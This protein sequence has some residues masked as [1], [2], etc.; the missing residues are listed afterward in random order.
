MCKYNTIV[1]DLDGTLLYTLED[2]LDG[3]NHT[4]TMFG[5]PARSLEEV[6][7]FVGNG[8]GKLIERSVPDDVSKS[9]YEIVLAAF[10]NYYTKNCQ[11]KTKPYDGIFEMLKELKQRNIK[12]AIVSNKNHKAVCELREKYFKDY[13]EVAIG[14]RTGYKRKPSP[15]SLHEA[16]KCLGSK[17]EESVYVGDSDVDLETAKN[18]GIEH[19]LVTWGFRDKEYLVKKGGKNF[20][21][22]PM[23]II[24][25]IK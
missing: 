14:D 12:L 13:I 19:V 24:T 22:E 17:V 1:F 21:D 7:S 4:M 3:V 25:Y 2:L 8:I 15:D 11:N 16:L 23:E 5:Y 10:R 6:R 20:I 18:A 9:Q